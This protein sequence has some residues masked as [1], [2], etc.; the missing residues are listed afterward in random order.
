LALQTV[1]KS[2]WVIPTKLLIVTAFWA[3][4]ES[5]FWFIAVDFLLVP[6]AV[7]FPR[8]WFKTAGVA[9]VASHCGGALYFLFCSSYMD[10]A[11]EIMAVTPFVS[12]RMH[13]FISGLYQNY[14]PWGAMAQSWS[15]MS[16]K[17]WTY[18]A[19]RHGFAFFPY[20]PLVMF[21]RIFR[22]FVVAWIAA[23]ASPFVL[24]IWSRGRIWSWVVYSIGFISMLIVIE[25]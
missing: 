5:S 21:S 6:F 18:E 10:L 14:G 7:M 23:K 2:A 17:I 4:A 12:Q 19:V 15:F 16:F 1:S 13:D 22:L 25:K 11:G 20:F 24:P 8:Q 9:W 3:F